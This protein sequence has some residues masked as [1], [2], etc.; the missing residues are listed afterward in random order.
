[1]G[2][3]YLI[4]GT[5]IAYRAFFALE[6][7]FQNQEG[8]PT[9]ATF[10]VVRMIKKI[11]DDFIR[12]DDDSIVFVMD[13]KTKTYRHELLESYKAQRPKAPDEFIIQIPYITEVVENMGIPV[14]TLDAHEA[15]D[16]SNTRCKRKK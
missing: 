9:N 11:L 16:N 12:L 1:M 8:I 5:G 4:D 2:D 6:G 7:F 14:L 15:D 3:L 10:G 13:K